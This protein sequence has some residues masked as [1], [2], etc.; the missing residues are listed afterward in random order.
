VPHGSRL[1][2]R[3]APSPR[4]R[5]ALHRPSWE[6][7]RGRGDAVE[8]R[9]VPPLVGDDSACLRDDLRASERTTALDSLKPV[10]DVKYKL[11]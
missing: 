9:G 7:N 6:P 10:S 11:Y 1:A 4:R 8:A 3:R 2:G 5:G